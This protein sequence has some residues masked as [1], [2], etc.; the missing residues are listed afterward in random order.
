MTKLMGSAMLAL[1]L[2]GLPEAPSWAQSNEG[3]ISSDVQNEKQIRQ[4]YT[5][6]VK[7]WNKHDVDAMTELWAIDGDT[8]EPDGTHAQGRTAV[9]ILLQREHQTVFDKTTIDLSVSD[10]WFPSENVALV[11]G[12]Y[13][14]TGIHTPW[15]QEL[16]ARR[17]HLT[18]VLIREN[19]RWWIAASRSSIPVTLPYREQKQ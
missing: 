16:P 3:G 8:M 5:D 11:D 19:G 2:G 4:L 6:F 14:I 17:G 9:G 15:G 13:E 10:V 12:G 18:S 1:G 7:A